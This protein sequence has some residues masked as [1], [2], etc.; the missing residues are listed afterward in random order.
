MSMSIEISISIAGM[1]ISVETLEP[2]TP[3]VSQAG[4][5]LVEGPLTLAVAARVVRGADHRQ[6]PSNVDL[7]PAARV[8]LALAAPVTSVAVV[9]HAMRRLA[10]AARVAL[11]ETF[12]AAAR[13]APA[14]AALVTSVAVV[15]HAAAH[16][17][18][19]THLAVVAPVAVVVV[20]AAQRAG[21]AHVAAVVM[22]AVTNKPVS[23]NET[24]PAAHCFRSG[25][26]GS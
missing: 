7:G 3:V 13:A 20:G 22:A 2:Q 8:A 4:E 15:A 23:S 14:L 5:L 11:P 10:V 17:V 19:A 24:M 18:V 21:A 9:A 1:P 16:L 26:G 25:D 6:P 12:R